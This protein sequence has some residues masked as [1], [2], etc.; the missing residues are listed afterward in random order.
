MAEYDIKIA[1][2]DGTEKILIDRC[3]EYETVSVSIYAKKPII[4]KAMP[5]IDDDAWV[6]KPRVYHFEGNVT[7]ANR[8]LLQTRKELHAEV[9]I[10][11][12][13]AVGTDVK[14]DDGW[15]ISLEFVWQG[16]RDYTY[17]WYVTIEIISEENI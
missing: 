6:A 15:I 10:S 12:E 13:N 7:D 1:K 9:R 14:I 4:N 16:E 8:K 17:P 3:K 2:A 11:E 5:T